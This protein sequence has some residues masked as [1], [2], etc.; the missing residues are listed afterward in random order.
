MPEQRSASRGTSRVDEVYLRLRG[1]ILS[2]Q[3]APGMKLHSATLCQ[4]YGASSGVL[5]EALPRLAGEGLVI[6]EAQRGYRVATVS[7]DDLQQLTE[8]RVLVETE[9]LRQS[10]AHGDL[11]F[12]SR[13][14]AAHH[15]LSRIDPIAADGSI[16][17]EWLAAHSEFHSAL[18]AGSPNLRLQAIA[19]SLR[20]A[21]EVYR[22]WSTKIGD[23]P[24]RDVAGEH[25]R[26]LDATVARDA[27]GAVAELTAHIEYSSQIL[28]RA[29]IGIAE[30]AAG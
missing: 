24:G 6:T 26:I 18:L 16:R 7:V 25:L 11:A 8:A 22:C 29:Q 30:A 1:D 19:S 28:I 9:T 2:G 14:I 27:D 4:R 17:E 23:G 3:H 21:T 12:E 13:L 5:R 10:I 15:T 20:D